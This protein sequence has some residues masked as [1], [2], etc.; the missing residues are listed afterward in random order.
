[1]TMGEVH[2]P[3]Q[4]Q[5]IYV[6]LGKSKVKISQHQKKL[7]GDLYIFLEG[8]LLEDRETLKPIG[9][10]WESLDEHNRWG[11]S[12]RGMI[13]SGKSSFVDTPHFERYV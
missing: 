8:V 11:G 1:V 9:D 3:P 12:W 13:E 5:K 4:M 10:F 2:R 7:A 6:S